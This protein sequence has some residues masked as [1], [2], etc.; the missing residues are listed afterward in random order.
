[1]VDLNDQKDK[2]TNNSKNSS[3]ERAAILDIVS[4]YLDPLYKLLIEDFVNRFN[5]QLPVS[6][7]FFFGMFLF[8][9]I[10]IYFNLSFQGSMFF[11]LLAV[12][13]FLAHN[14]KLVVNI[15]TKKILFNKGKFVDEFIKNIDTKDLDETKRFIQNNYHELTSADLILLMNSKFND[16][17][18]FHSSILRN[19][20]IDSELL[21]FMIE[22]ALDIKIGEETFCD[23]LKYCSTSISHRSYYLLAER[24]KNDP[25]VIQ[26]INACYPAYIRNHNWFRFFANIRIQFKE[27]INYGNF[28]KYLFLFW[29][30]FGLYALSTHPTALPQAI[31]IAT[32]DETT[33]VLLGIITI[34]NY[35]LS[36]LL[37]IAIFTFVTLWVIMWFLRRYRSFLCYFAPKSIE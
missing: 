25:N 33:R 16:N 35:C 1:M 31:N 3:E 32:N 18:S 6:F 17:S 37:T 7:F 8:S 26:V 11:L 12:V 27:S 34:I 21:E 30:V 22:N 14:R 24:H 36:F 2:D 28:K 15:I 10:T 4:P 13:I 29:M 23:Y 20:I 5:I 19:Q 9:I